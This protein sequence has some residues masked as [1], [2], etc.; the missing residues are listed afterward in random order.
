MNKFIF[1]EERDKNTWFRLK[2][3]EGVGETV[4]AVSVITFNGKK[5]LKIDIKYFSQESAGAYRVICLEEK[6]R[7]VIKNFSITSGPGW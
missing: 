1:R 2:N 5:A 4:S 7:L 6:N 3:N